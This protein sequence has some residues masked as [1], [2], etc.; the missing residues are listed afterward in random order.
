M[1]EITSHLHGG[2]PHSDALV[3]VA[4]D[5]ARGRRPGSDL[6]RRRQVDQ[7][8]LEALQREAGLALVSS[9]MLGWL[10]LFRPLAAACP[11]W[12]T[13]P[14]W[15]W[16]ATNAFI[17]I[18]VVRGTDGLDR[19]LLTAALDFDGTA[20]PAGEVGTLPGPHTFSRIVDADGDRELLMDYL[21][22]NVLRPARRGADRPRRANDPPAGTLAG[23]ARGRVTRLVLPCRVPG[24]RGIIQGRDALGAAVR[25]SLGSRRPG[26]GPGGLRCSRASRPRRMFPGP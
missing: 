20:G 19:D 9:G 18:P 17:R 16:F 24:N 2:F 8:G 13:G 1:T 5:V 23:S 10:D 3:A 14:L 25:S 15:R 26:R 11:G 7:A 12:G 4:R 22:A 6:L 21:A